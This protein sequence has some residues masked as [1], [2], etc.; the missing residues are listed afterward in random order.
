MLS[1]SFLWLLSQTTSVSLCH[2]C[3]WFLWSLFPTNSCSQGEKLSLDLSFSFLRYLFSHP[4]LS[5]LVG[6]KHLLES[7]CFCSTAVEAKD[8]T[9]GSGSFVDP[10]VQTATSSGYSCSSLVL[11]FGSIYPLTA[12]LLLP[13]RVAC[14]TAGG[15]G[16]W[17][18]G[19]VQAPRKTALPAK[20][21]RQP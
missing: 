14:C 10:S 17:N 7:R 9:A 18:Y 13:D 19:T 2:L 8:V 21:L 3:S 16:L 12:A 4:L 20:S 1:S 15:N 6:I 5:A 11:S